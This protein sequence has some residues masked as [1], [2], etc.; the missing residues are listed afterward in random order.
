MNAL[1]GINSNRAVSVPYNMYV[2][3]YSHSCIVTWEDDDNSAW[4]LRYR[5]YSEEPEEP[6]LL[7]SLSGSAYTGN[8]ADITLPAPWSGVNVRG[9]NN[10]IYIKNNYNNVAQGYIKYTIPEGYNNA[11][12]TLMVTSQNSA[13]DGVGDVT[14]STPQTAAVSHNFSKNETFY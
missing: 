6:V 4:N 10:A 11:T 8:Y 5:L 9:G 1:A 7:H 13:S 2:E 3:P 12:F 14:V